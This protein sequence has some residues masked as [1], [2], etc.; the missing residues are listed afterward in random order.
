MRRTP[1]GPRRSRAT[2]VALITP[3]LDSSGGIGRLMSYV[4]SSIPA[5]DIDIRV[6]DPRGPSQR[7]VLSIAPLMRAWLELVILGVAGR[8]DV[9]H[10]NMSSGGSSLR[11]PVMLWTCRLFRVPVVLHLHASEYPEFFAS[12]PRAAKALL[13]RTF[14]RADIVLVLGVRWQQY[15][16][17]ELRVPA[18]KVSVLLNASPGPDLA[19]T[20]HPR[21]GDPLRVLFL[22]RLGKRKGVPEI[23]QALADVRVRERAWTAVLAGDGD[24]AHYRLEAR[25]LGLDDRVIFRAWLDAEEVSRLLADSHVLLLPSRAEGLPMAMVEAFAHAVPVVG[26][27]VGAMPDV[28][29]GGINGLIVRAGDSGQLADAL[30]TLLDDEELRLRLARNAR[31]T[32]EE[33]LDIVAYTRSLAMCWRGVSAA[34]GNRTG[35]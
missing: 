5:D 6:L 21:N 16:C 11:K 7:P 26:T 33:R 1:F 23:L 34:A 27:P 10:I 9:A 35:P 15:V 8:V 20:L 13:R 31:R 25:R 3:P 22:G 12:M 4:V 14:S 19:P 24:I 2:R 17:R 28:L 29:E 18:A 30:L 32:W